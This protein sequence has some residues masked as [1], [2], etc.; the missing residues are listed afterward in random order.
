MCVAQLRGQIQRRFVSLNMLQMKERAGR[1]IYSKREFRTIGRWGGAR[2]TFSVTLDS[3][4]LDAWVRA[5]IFSFF[6]FFFIA[7]VS[8]RFDE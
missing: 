3:A 5:R 7:E 4:D 2:L 1:V 8:S 6:F